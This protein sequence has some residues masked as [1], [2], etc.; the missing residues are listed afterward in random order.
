MVVILAQELELSLQVE[1]TLKADIL[2]PRSASSMHHQAR[3]YAGYSSRH[4]FNEF[5]VNDSYEFAGSASPRLARFKF[6]LRNSTDIL[7]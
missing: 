1:A 4:N 3:A 2:S 7:W 6:E 5:K